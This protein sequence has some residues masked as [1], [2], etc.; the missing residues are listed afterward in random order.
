MMGGSGMINTMKKSYEQNCALL[1]RGSMKRVTV[2]LI[3]AITFSCQ[4]KSSKQEAIAYLDNV[5]LFIKEVKT[6]IDNQN[7][8]LTILAKKSIIENNGN[9]G[10]GDIND[11]RQINQ[12]TVKTTENSI[13]LVQNLSDLAEEDSYKVATLKYL[14]SVLEMEKRVVPKIIAIF[15]EGL[16]KNNK[17]ELKS[18][19]VELMEINKMSDEYT[20]AQEA[21][22]QEYELTDEE[23]NAIYKKHGL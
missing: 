11:L 8:R 5:L 7:H 12:E 10:K 23:V 17:G 19:I 6:K 13:K 20:K 9:M 22:Y 3:V 4:Y 18:K 1:K 21:Y 2:I 14:R 16:S 15:D